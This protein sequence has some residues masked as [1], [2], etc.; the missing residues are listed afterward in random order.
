ML[1]AFWTVFGIILFCSSVIASGSLFTLASELSWPPSLSLLSTLLVE[2]VC[3]D[4]SFSSDSG[5]GSALSSLSLYCELDWESS[6]TSE[7]DSLFCSWLSEFDSCFAFSC[8]IN[9]LARTF[10]SSKVLRLSISSRTHSASAKLISADF[11]DL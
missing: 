4:V 10:T 9:F 8:S 3:S 1:S 2:V 7:E 5:T 6:E 11:D